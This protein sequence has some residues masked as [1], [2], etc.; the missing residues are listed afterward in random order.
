MIQ[1]GAL[2]SKHANIEFQNPA[3]AERNKVG[4]RR[5]QGWITELP[6]KIEREQEHRDAGG[7]R[8]DI[9]VSNAAASNA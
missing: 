8:L 2:E 3:F 7:L 5:R 1:K 6:Q 9:Q 4:G